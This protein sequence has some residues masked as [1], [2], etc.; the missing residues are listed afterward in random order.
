MMDKTTDLKSET[1]KQSKEKYY[2]LLNWKLI[3]GDLL[4]FRGRVDVFS[5]LVAQMWVL[6]SSNIPQERLAW[7]VG[8]SL[9]FV[10]C[11][12]THS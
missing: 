9:L 10:W 3:L 8:M 4:M 2:Y 6:I 1:S 12:A 11:I 5:V 7:Y